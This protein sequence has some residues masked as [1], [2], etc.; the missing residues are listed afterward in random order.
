VAPD[1]GDAKVL[2]DMVHTD[3]HNHRA[4]SA[5]SE[6]VQAVKILVRAH[7]SMI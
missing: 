1:P 5:G 6:A 2:A 7:Q 4:V 3:R